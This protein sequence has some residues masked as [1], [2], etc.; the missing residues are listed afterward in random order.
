MEDAF[1]AELEG[2][3]VDPYLLVGRPHIGSP[4]YKVHDNTLDLR[5]ALESHIVD[6][7]HMRWEVTL[8][9]SPYGLVHLEARGTYDYCG[10]KCCRIRDTW[11]ATLRLTGRYNG[12]TSMS[13]AL[14]WYNEHGAPLSG[15]PDINDVVFPLDAITKTI[16]S[17]C[18]S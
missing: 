7:E 3:L 4:T 9:K 6:M 11:E 14:Q 17:G 15:D 13:R 1:R 8:N 18:V 10:N 12:M 2:H 5:F 16:C